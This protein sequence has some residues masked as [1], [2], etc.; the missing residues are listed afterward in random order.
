MDG[1]AQ[2]WHLNG[3]KYYVKSYKNDMPDADVSIQ[4]DSR[5]AVR[6]ANNHSPWRTTADSKYGVNI[7]GTIKITK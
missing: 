6:V 4:L 5:Y 1:V 2:Q 3:E 7:I